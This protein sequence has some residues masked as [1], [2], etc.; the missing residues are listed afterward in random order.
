MTPSTTPTRPRRPGPCPYTSPNLTWTGNL[1]IGATATITFTVTVNNPDTGNDILANTVTS[2]TSGSNCAAGQHER[3]CTATIPVSVL[4]IVETASASTA[5]P[6]ATVSYTVTVTNSG[7]VAYTSARF[8]DALTWVL[9]DA[10]LQ[11]QRDRDRGHRVVLPA[12]T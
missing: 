8:T 4:T 3:A 1:A 6:G 2:T 9:D 12:R 10:S 11:R 5:T 7:Q